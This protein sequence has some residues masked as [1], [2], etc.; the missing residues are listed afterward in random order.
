[1]QFVRSG[2]NVISIAEEMSYP[3]VTEPLLAKD[4]GGSGKKQ[5]RDDSGTG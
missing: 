3:H 4:N 5:R 1:M 2:K